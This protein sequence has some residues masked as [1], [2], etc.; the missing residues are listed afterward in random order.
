MNLYDILFY[1][2]ICEGVNFLRISEEEHMSQSAVSKL[3]NRLETYTGKKLIN[4]HQGKPTFSITEDGKVFLEFSLK[5]KKII[6]EMN[7]YYSIKCH[8]KITI[9]VSDLV[10]TYLI[11]LLYEE[12]SKNCIFLLDESIENNIKYIK[13]LES[14]KKLENF[15]DTIIIELYK[16]ELFLISS[17]DNKFIYTNNMENLTY[18]TSKKGSVLNNC[19]NTFIEKNNIKT[20]NINI[21]SDIQAIK[22]IVALSEKVTLLP[23]SMI[24]KRDDL[25]QT[26]LDK[27]QFLY[28][29][30]IINKELY[31]R[32]EE[33][34]IFVSLKNF[35]MR[36]FKNS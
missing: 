36:Y 16:E 4:R 14:D 30:L 9:L 35:Y 33:K 23:Y 3:I 32:K 13:I 27:K 6:E 19:V 26:T 24:D 10:M 31:K 1:C 22:N 28:Y 11:P 2:K 17:I 15:V 18:L 5:I 12:Y 34:D 7:E 25:K 29:Y 8:N 20:K 21:I